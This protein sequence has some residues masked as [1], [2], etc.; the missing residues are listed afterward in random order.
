MSQP[1]ASDATTDWDAKAL[2]SLIW[3]ALLTIVIDVGLMALYTRW[4]FHPR[5]AFLFM[6]AIY[7]WRGTWFGMWFLWGAAA[8]PWRKAGGLT[9]TCLGL[10]LATPAALLAVGGLPANSDG[11]LTIVYG[12]EVAA[13]LL[14]ARL[15]GLRVAHT[16]I[17]GNQRR[18]QW[19]LKSLAAV[20]TIASIVF[21]VV[22]IVWR[23]EQ[24]VPKTRPV[25]YTGIERL[26][27]LSSMAV[28]FG[29]ATALALILMTRWGR[30]AASIV[31]AVA[32]VIVIWFDFSRSMSW[33]IAEIGMTLIACVVFRERMEQD[34]WQT[35]FEPPFWERV[36]VASSAISSH[37]S[38]KMAI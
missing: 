34:G 2:S 31:G 21:W 9:A 15:F 23:F 18:W 19:S 29:H 38:D 4:M 16:S 17:A 22:G 25:V 12:A 3:L 1:T 5:S 37:P 32:V 13:W 36:S 6:L 7:A 28:S 26:F 35:Y 30:Y 14:V 27:I 33:V 8:S 10:L 11:R 24:Y 20:V